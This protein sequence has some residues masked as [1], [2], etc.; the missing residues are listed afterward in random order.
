MTANQ[1]RSKLLASSTGV[2]IGITMRMMAT[3]GRNMPAMSKKKLMAS[4]SIH[5]FR[6]RSTIHW[7]A[8]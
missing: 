3:V 7:A 4:I 2:R 6:L 8:L 5:R 1:I